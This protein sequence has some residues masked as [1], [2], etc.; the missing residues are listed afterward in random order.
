MDDVIR[1]GLS[2]T[3]GMRIVHR[4]RRGRP[5]YPSVLTRAEWRVLAALRAGKA[6]AAIASEQGVSVHT[7]RSQVSSIL[8]KL[9]VSSRRELTA[10]E[11][12]MADNGRRMRCSFCLKA[13]DEVRYML[14][15]G[16]GVYICGDCVESCN[17]ILAR[18]RAG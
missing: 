4:R 17:R 11:G 13:E 7:V 10:T 5:R 3:H 12:E 9:G 8:R 2:Y 15:G 6:N 18:Q 14:G 16:A 1:A